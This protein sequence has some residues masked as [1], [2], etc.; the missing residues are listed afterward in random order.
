MTT[1][2]LPAS[3]DVPAITARRADWFAWLRRTL[4][5]A[6]SRRHLAEMDQ[7]MLTDIGISRAEALQEAGRAPWDHTPRQG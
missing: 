5:A 1:R 3:H 4:Q 7:R 2:S 6:E